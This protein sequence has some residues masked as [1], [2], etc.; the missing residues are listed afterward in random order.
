MIATPEYNGGIPGTLKN[1]I[2]WASRD[3]SDPFEKKPIL[4]LGLLPAVSEPFEGSG[5]HACRWK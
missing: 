5:I 4:L 3:D 1:A 2:D